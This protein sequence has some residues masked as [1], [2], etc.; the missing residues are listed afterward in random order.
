M[1][2]I[3]IKIKE[4]EPSEDSI[5]ARKNFPA[6]LDEYQL[7]KSSYT[8]ITTIWGS[9]VGLAVLTA[10]AVNTTA[11]PKYV[12]QMTSINPDQELTCS[13]ESDE[14][15]KSSENTSET[16][17]TAAGK[18]HATSHASINTIEKATQVQAAKFSMINQE[19]EQEQEDK[20]QKEK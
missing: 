15:Y 17:L 18:N 11:E 13:S 8:K 16:T 5:L 19:E 6:I 12:K 4:K 3:K 7:I 20:K 10:F 2:N 1:K 9:A 14:K